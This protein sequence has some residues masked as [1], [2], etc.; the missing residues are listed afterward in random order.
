V[1]VTVGCQAGVECANTA[2]DN[3]THADGT[4]D[5]TKWSHYHLVDQ[6]HAQYKSNQCW[7]VRRS[8]SPPEYACS[9]YNYF[10]RKSCST[11]HRVYMAVG[12]NL[13]TGFDFVGVRGRVP[14]ADSLA[15][16]LAK[17]H[18]VGTPSDGDGTAILSVQTSL[19]GLTNIA[20]QNIYGYPSGIGVQAQG[21]SISLIV[22]G[23]KIRT[24]TDTTHQS[25]QFTGM[26]FETQAG[27][28]NDG[29]YCDDWNFTNVMI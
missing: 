11:D 21:T 24:V 5:A 27:P 6:L 13:Y 23:V 12:P 18:W 22:D 28:W 17:V 8:S 3:F 25:G 10:Y 2:S 29:V 16:Y 4:F 1:P 14:A 7:F 9:I 15:G 20:S 26:E 19:G